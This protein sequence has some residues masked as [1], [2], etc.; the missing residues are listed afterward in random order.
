MQTGIQQYFD[1]ANVQNAFKALDVLTMI[2]TFNYNKHVTPKLQKGNYFEIEHGAIENPAAPLINIDGSTPEFKN[3]SV[4]KFIDKFEAIGNHKLMGAEEYMNRSEGAAN[5][6]A[7]IAKM[8]E[9]AELAV[10]SNKMRLEDIFL[11]TFST[12]KLILTAKTNNIKGINK[13]IDYRVPAAQKVGVAVPWSSASTAVPIDNIR[14]HTE[15]LRSLGKRP[16]K[17]RMKRVVLQRLLACKQVTDLNLMNGAGTANDFVTQDRFNTFLQQLGL[18]IIELIEDNVVHSDKNGKIVNIDSF[19]ENN[20]VFV[21]SDNY[22]N[23][24]YRDPV[25]ERKVGATKAG[26]FTMTNQMAVLSTIETTDPFSLKI[27]AKLYGIIILP[28]IYN[29]GF[30]STEN[31]TFQYS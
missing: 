29:F 2:D 25:T 7:T 15:T 24:L 3:G 6:S 22:G 12:T 5:R 4:E 8:G 31:T 17:I 11:R 16:I 30:M 23:L 20:I 27:M 14:N 9:L 21:D 18:P 1:A 10:I 19:V 26:I 13:T 28:Q